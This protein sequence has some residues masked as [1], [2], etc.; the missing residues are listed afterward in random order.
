MRL[1][2]GGGVNGIY[3]IVADVRKS[4]LRKINLNLDMFE[5]NFCVRVMQRCVT[6][7]LIC[8]TWVFFRAGEMSDLVEILK[9]MFVFNPGILFDGTMYSLGVSKGFFG[10]LVIFILILLYV[11]YKKYHSI[12]VINHVLSKT[13]WVQSLVYA[14]MIFIIVMFGCY[15]VEY[16]T[17]Q[18][19]YFQF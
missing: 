8:F 12:N 6:F 9:N 7:A 1:F 13:W 2:F 15:G 4:L 11:D 5:N 18:F 19:I 3:Q 10:L 14:L 17:S 16:D